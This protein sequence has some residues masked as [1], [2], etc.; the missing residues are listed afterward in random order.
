MGLPK[1][2]PK[3]FTPRK[4]PQKGRGPEITW[5]YMALTHLSAPSQMA[6]QSLGFPYVS[7]LLP[8]TGVSRGSDDQEKICWL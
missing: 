4:C 1:K 3:L 5:E 6:P 7:E 8:A 2:H